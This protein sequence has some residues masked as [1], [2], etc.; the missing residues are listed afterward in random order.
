M[1]EEEGRR[2][3]T[4]EAL[5]VAEQ[6]NKELKKQLLEEQREKKIAAAILDNVEKQAE[7][8]RVLLRNTED[9]LIASKTQIVA[10][11]KKLEEAEKAK[12]QISECSLDEHRGGCFLGVTDG[13]TFR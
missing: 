6:S 12:V 4:V 5:N 2:N 11:K 9:Q 7:S 8:Q 3:A 10:L 1:K 13:L